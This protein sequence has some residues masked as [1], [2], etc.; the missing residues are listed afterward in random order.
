M[1]FNRIMIFRTLFLFT[2]IT[3]FISCS[4]SNPGSDGSFQ[5]INTKEAVE[6]IKKN[7]GNDNF[8]ILDI[9]TQREHMQGHIE[10][11]ILVEF[12][13]STLETEL[14]KLDKNKTYF[15]YCR[16]GNRSSISMN[17]MKKLGFTQV[18]NL[19]GGTIDWTRSGQ[20]LTTQ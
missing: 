17:L 10:N 2:F 1:Q 6:L 16:S 12:N 20:T 19:K 18:Y 11:S 7:A 8:M 3:V 5:N 14:K 4:S 15:I 13:P 9:R